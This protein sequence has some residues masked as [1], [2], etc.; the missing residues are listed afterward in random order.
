MGLGV[1]VVSFVALTPWLSWCLIVGCDRSRWVWVD[2]VVV[3]GLFGR[4]GGC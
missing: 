1:I 2:L 4:L 3:I